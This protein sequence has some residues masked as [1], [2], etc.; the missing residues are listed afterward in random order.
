VTAANG[1]GVFLISGGTITKVA[2]PGDKIR[3]EAL[4]FADLP[5]INGLGDIAFAP[6]S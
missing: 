1:N 2:V 4:T 5:Q 6:M 3:N